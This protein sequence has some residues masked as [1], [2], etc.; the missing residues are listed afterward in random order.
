MRK[1]ERIRRRLQWHRKHR[2]R[3]R[4]PNPRVRHTARRPSQHVPWLRCVGTIV[5][6]RNEPSQLHLA[7][8]VDAMA[9]ETAIE[10]QDVTSEEHPVDTIAM[11][12]DPVLPAWRMPRSALSVMR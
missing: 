5:Q 6:V 12:V 4:Q 10:M 9:D 1:L 11:T 2:F 8:D 3:L 7:L